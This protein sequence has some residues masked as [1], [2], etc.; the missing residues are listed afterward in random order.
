MG[1]LIDSSVLIEAE[2]GRLDLR[3]HVG[4]RAGDEVLVSVVSVSELLLGAYR[5]R[6]AAE[7]N[8]R[9]G[10]AEALLSRFKSVVID[11]PV[12]RLHAQL[13]ADLQSRGTPIGPHDLWLA[14]TCLA[15]GLT[16]VTTN[17]REFG[18]VPGLVVE[19]WS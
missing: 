10:I 8:R 1:V 2:R 6:D 17:L 14:A 12:A 13:K 9:L 19:S 16:M 15:H 4:R 7:R 11:V 3:A 18:R 5:A